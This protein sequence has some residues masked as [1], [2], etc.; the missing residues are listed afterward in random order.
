MGLKEG[1]AALRAP[2]G[3]GAEVVAAGGAEAGRGTAANTLGEAASGQG[4]ECQ[5]RE[6]MGDDDDPRRVKTG[7]ANESD[8]AQPPRVV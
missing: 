4:R 7:A 2:L 6:P 3:R 1:E 5:R 8:G